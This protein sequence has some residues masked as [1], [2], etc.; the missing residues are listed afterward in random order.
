[1]YLLFMLMLGVALFLFTHYYPSHPY[2][3][4]TFMAYLENNVL[5]Y[6]KLNKAVE[7]FV[8]Y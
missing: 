7:F 5:P 2:L 4:C 8:F 6:R 1:M 3:Y